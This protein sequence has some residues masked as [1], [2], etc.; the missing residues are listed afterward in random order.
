MEHCESIIAQM[1][2]RP[3]FRSIDGNRAFYSPALDFVNMPAIA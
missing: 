2:K 1:P 3:E